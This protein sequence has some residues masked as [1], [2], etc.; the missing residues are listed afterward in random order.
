MKQNENA[1]QAK[2][3]PILDTYR[4]VYRHFDDIPEIARIISRKR[5]LICINLSARKDANVDVLI[6]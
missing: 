1:V 5:K 6:E 2:R 4:V 3:T